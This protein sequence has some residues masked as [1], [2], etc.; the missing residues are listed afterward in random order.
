MKT[1]GE[2]EAYIYI[3]LS[4]APVG[5]E[6]VVLRPG[7]FTPEERAAGAHCIGGCVDSRAGLYNVEKRKF[8]TLPGLEV[9]PLSHPVHSQSLYRLRY[10]SSQFR[11]VIT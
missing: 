4:S 8:F 2:M 3:F 6:W 9:R 11:K 1:Y 5:G 7:P 10:R